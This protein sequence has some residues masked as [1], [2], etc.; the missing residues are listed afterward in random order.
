MFIVAF[1]EFKLLLTSLISDFKAPNNPVWAL[2]GVLDCYLLDLVN[3][4]FDGS[5]SVI[6]FL[7]SK[8]RPL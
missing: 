5:I 1:S 7:S 8:L 4:S 2:I 3:Y 6:F